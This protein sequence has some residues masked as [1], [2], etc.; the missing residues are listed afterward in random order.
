MADRY[1]LEISLLG[2][3][4]R[5]KCELYDGV[6]ELDE[7]RLGMV[8]ADALRT[9]CQYKEFDPSAVLAHLCSE[10]EGPTTGIFHTDSTGRPTLKVVEN[11]P[12][13]GE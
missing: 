6:N 7:S 5:V 1:I 8:L 9:A 12:A 3:S 4:T 11:G 2:T 13:D 10:V